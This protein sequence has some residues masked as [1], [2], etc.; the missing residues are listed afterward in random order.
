MGAAA[1]ETSRTFAKESLLVVLAYLG[2]SY[3]VRRQGFVHVSDDDFARTVIAQGFAHAPRLDP[4]GTS[5]L[6][7]PFYLTGTAMMA[8][9]RSFAVARTVSLVLTTG[10]LGLFYFYARRFFSGIAPRW[11]LWIGFV[12]LATFPWMVF[13]G[14]AAVPEAYASIWMAIAIA[15]LAWRT[16]SLVPALLLLLATLCRYEA[17]TAALAFAI[18]RPLCS[19]GSNRPRA[20]LYGVLPLAGP[21]AW[22]AWNRFSH[23]EYTHFFSRV[24]KY[25][26]AFETPPLTTRIL[27]YP[28]ALFEAAPEYVL[29]GAGLVFSFLWL[30]RD[31]KLRLLGVVFCVTTMGVVLIAGNVKDG[32]PTH[33][34]VRAMVPIVAASVPL[35]IATAV[36]VAHRLTGPSLA[37]KTWVVGAMAGSL[38]VYAA[39]LPSRGRAFPKDERTS[40]VAEG[41]RL[42]GV[43]QL[44]VEPCAYEHFALIAGYEAPERVEILP[45]KKTET[46]PC[47]AVTEQKAP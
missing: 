15:S 14:N 11:G 35:A 37:R 33:H 20:A 13:L 41:A 47:P 42:R 16:P 43:P 9:G 27:Q 4:S 3:W 25:R 38:L 23:G 22:M 31:T 40:L 36:G 12:W 26:A 2:A 18:A 1:A 32:A 21:A 29:L 28:L 44:R 39:F 5:W 7:V 10:S 46:A 8:F 34:A 6:P 19:P 30:P 17:W 24:S 45:K